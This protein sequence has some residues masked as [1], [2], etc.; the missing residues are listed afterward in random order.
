M[1]SIL[2]TGA[3][4]TVGSNLLQSLA[5][6]PGVSVRAGTRDLAKLRAATLSPNVVPV[7]FDYTRPAT[8]RAALD[9]V[10]KLYLLTPLSDQQVN[11]ARTLIDAAGRA[12]VR[13]VVRQSEWSC[14]TDRASPL[15]RWHAEIERYVAASGMTW[16]VLRPMPFMTNFIVFTPPNA[17]G[18]IYAPL[19]ASATAY[20]DPRDIA[21]AAAAI[22]TSDSH[23]GR[24]YTL[25][26]PAALTTSDVASA[27]SAASGRTIRYV[28]VSDE[29]AR[30]AMSEMGVPL[31]INEAII[32]AYVL[33]RLDQTSEVTDS[34]RELTGHLPRRIDEFARDMAA[35]WK[36]PEPV[37]SGVIHR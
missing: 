3:A 25:T 36:S 5:D 12:G 14:R 20:V 34:V 18:V 24:T 31:V 33:M 11:W 23:G 17:D 19:G 32:E 15:R 2:V 37:A 27:L 10:E 21:D 7:E 26:G 29:M 13:H 4:G 30:G 22:L 16:T 35:A 8:M 28:D 6:R 9:G 1:T